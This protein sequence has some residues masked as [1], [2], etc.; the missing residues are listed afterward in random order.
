MEAAITRF[1]KPGPDFIDLKR[2]TA[3]DFSDD[4]AAATEGEDAFQECRVMKSDWIKKRIKAADDADRFIGKVKGLLEDEPEFGIRWNLSWLQLGFKTPG[5]IETPSDLNAKM[6]VLRSAATWLSKNLKMEVSEGKTIITHQRA[7]ELEQA[8][9]NAISKIDEYDTKGGQC[10]DVR[11]DAEE[12]FKKRIGMVIDELDFLLDP[13]DPRWISFG[14]NKPGET[15]RPDQPLNVQAT[16]I[17]PNRLHLTWGPSARRSRYKVRVLIV[18]RDQKPKTVTEVFEEETDLTFETGQ[19]VKV[20][21]IATNGAGDSAP[22]ETIE[23]HIASA[24]A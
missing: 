3:K 17:A 6:E 8:L 7:G 13:M 15:Q 1:L 9:S 18:G 21:I 20:E 22:S 12:T 4:F 23:R 14:L 16:V 24:A 2:T 19:T 11:Q 10:D 5:T